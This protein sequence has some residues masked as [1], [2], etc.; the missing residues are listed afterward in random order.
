[1]A[2]QVPGHRFLQ[3]QFLRDTARKYVF[4][5]NHKVIGVQYYLLGLFA[6]GG[7]V[8]ESLL[9]RVHLAWPRLPMP[10][11]STLSPIGAPG[12]IMTPEI[13]LALLT[14]H[15]TLMVFFVA[16]TVPQAAFGS[17]FLPLQI[18][19][20]EM[21]F[22]R[23]N[24]VAFWL[25]VL[26]LALLLSTVFTAGGPP[27]SGWTASPPMSALGSIAGPGEGMGQTLWLVS[28]GI[29]SIAS[30][31]VA[32]NFIATTLK[33]RTRGMSLMRLPLTVWAWFITAILMAF[34]F[35]VLLIATA[36]LLMDHIGGYSFFLPANLVVSGVLQRYSGGSPLLWDH[37]FW[38]FRHPE[39]YIAIVPGIGL[40]SHL[41]SVFC[42]KPVFGY[43]AVLY[44]T[45]AIG[46]FGLV[47]QDHPMLTKGTNSFPALGLSVVAMAVVIPLVVVI[48]SWLATL[49]GGA[50][51]L[52]AA[53]LFSLSF[54]TVFSTA[55]VSCIFLAQTPLGLYL[56]GTYFMVA[57]LH[58]MMGLAAI[59][60]IFAG[61]Y[62][63]F[64]KVTG[65]LLNETLAR[66]HFGFTFVGCY[67][68]FLPMYFFGLSGLPDCYATIKGVPTLAA[69][70]PWNVFI[71][72]AALATAAVQPLF[73]FNLGRSLLKG[74][75][76]PQNPWE[77][78]TL[79]WTIPSPPPAA[80]FPG[81]PPIIYRYPY[82]Y[83]AGSGTRDYIMQHELKAPSAPSKAAFC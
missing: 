4:S 46:L 32:T 68:I 8:M 17:Y 47:V 2:P 67:C 37:L 5:S 14:M 63:W 48:F 20:R 25:T 41:L 53:M 82:E 26:S 38:F 21:A 58:L 28:I 22:P 18:G 40:T 74:A 27:T 71:T 73:L 50:I 31:L 62:F 79:E 10:W 51:R 52:T 75:R 39:V 9:M 12:G 45:A 83:G 3:P 70:Q 57:H 19:S 69:L 24:M 11:L 80:N 65:R 35:T 49:W 78:T 15:G 72:G 29:F 34:A 30:L 33:S 7:G 61:T 6:V 54:V 60:A 44:A 64:P 16:T 42:R 76:S 59:F 1:M 81:D 55:S 56:R 43:H 36:L 66:I 77:G 13:Y 23:L